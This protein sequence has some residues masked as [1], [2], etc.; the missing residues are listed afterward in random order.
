MKLLL[1]TV[2]I[3]GITIIGLIL[4]TTLAGFFMSKD[5]P[6]GTQGSEADQLAQHILTELNY[7]A[8]QKTEVISWTFAG[9]HSYEWHKNENYVIVSS[10]D[11]KVKLDLKNYEKSEV[12]SSNDMNDET[13]IET[14]IK[15]FNNDS[16]WLIA[17]YKIMEDNVERRLVTSNNHEK[18]LLV[19]YTSGGTTPGDSYLWKVNENYRPVSFKMWVSIIPVGGLEAKWK[20]WIETQ[21][22]MILST[23]KTVFGIPIEISDL[24]TSR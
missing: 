5:L 3:I 22:G 18:S 14:S 6:E 8:Y 4:I 17:P 13:L 19:T 20:D 16:F 2:K 7:E 1:K 12:I 23:E 9:L 24:K 21:S 11:Y 10:D 15:N